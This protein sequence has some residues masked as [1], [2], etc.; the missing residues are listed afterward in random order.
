MRKF[1]IAAMYLASIVP[2]FSRP[3][4]RDGDVDLSFGLFGAS[5]ATFPGG[6]YAYG[7]FFFEPTLQPD[8]KL[9]VAASKYQTPT[10]VDFG[11]LRLLRPA[12][13]F[14][15]MARSLSLASRSSMPP[16][17]RNFR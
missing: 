5:F 17:M 10:N 14:S 3:L 12:S 4:Q 6:A 7:G 15:R 13:Q 8:G 2:V 16:A 1:L 9:L 11:V